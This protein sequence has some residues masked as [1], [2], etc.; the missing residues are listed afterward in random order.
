MFVVEIMGGTSWMWILN[1]GECGGVFYFFGMTTC[2]KKNRGQKFGH[3]NVYLDKGVWK[4][5]YCYVPYGKI[6]PGYC[7]LFKA[8]C[9]FPYMHNECNDLPLLTYSGDGLELVAVTYKMVISMLE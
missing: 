8:N 5:I 6:I 3:P 2:R 4:C 1:G 7:I 9:K